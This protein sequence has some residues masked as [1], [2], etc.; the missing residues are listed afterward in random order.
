MLFAAAENQFALRGAAQGSDAS[1][2]LSD[3][4]REHARVYFAKAPEILLSPS[5]ATAPRSCTED[6]ALAVSAGRMSSDAVLGAIA[7][8]FQA[9]PTGESQD[10]K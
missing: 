8:D 6:A 3:A 7:D 2:A 4:D 5:I 1:R 10:R 9:S